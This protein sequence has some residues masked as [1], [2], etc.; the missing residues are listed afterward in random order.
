M[1]PKFPG[2]SGRNS[3]LLGKGLQVNR[4]NASALSVENR[5]SINEYQTLQLNN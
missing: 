5:F 1:K 4:L 2:E 3:E